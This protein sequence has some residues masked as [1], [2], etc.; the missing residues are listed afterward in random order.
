MLDNLEQTEDK[1]PNSFSYDNLSSVAVLGEDFL[2]LIHQLSLLFDIENLEGDILDKRV[3]QITGLKRKQPT[4]SYGLV[5]VTGRPG[6]VIPQESKFMANGVEF[7]ISKEYTIPEEGTV[8]VMVTCAEPGPVGNISVGMINKVEPDII[9][10]TEV[11]NPLEIDNGYIME[12]DSELRERYYEKLENPPKAGNPAHYKMWAEEVDGIGNAK[13]FRTWKGPSTVKVVLVGMDRTGVDE[14]M[15]QKV[16]DH[17]MEEAP[18]HWENLTVESAE[19]VPIQITVKIRLKN[20]YILETVKEN[21]TYNIEQ[22]LYEVSFRQSF[23]SYA[24]IGGAILSSDGVQDYE[25]LTINGIMDN[26]DL[27]DVQVGTLGEIEVTT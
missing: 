18:I 21:I 17:I 6:T 7:T 27:E 1:S 25:D 2:N 3:Y 10:V 4:Q 23:V 26:I 11:T 22:Y 24:K 12:T 16:H 9:G 14:E 13:V 8:S 15:V 20:G 5:E 19:E